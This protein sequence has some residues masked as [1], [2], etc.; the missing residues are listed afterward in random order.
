[1]T[2]FDQIEHAC[3]TDVGVRRSHN[4]D[5]FAVQLAGDDDGWKT[6]GHLFLVAD[7]MGAH[8]VGE[9]ASEQA[10]HIIPHIYQKHAAQGPIAGL[11]KAFVEANASIHQCGQQ[12]REFEGM[13]TTGTAL[14]LRPDGAWVG[15]VGDS[16]C[17]RV[18]GGVIEQLSYDHSLVW[19]YARLQHLDPDEVEDI[20]SNVIHRCLGPEPLVQVDVEGPHDIQPGDVFLLCSDGL[21]GPV[22][23]PEMGAI[24]S[25]LPPAEACRFLIDLANLRGG[26]D[27]IT[28]IVVRVLNTAGAT[29]AKPPKKPL[30]ARLPWWSLTLTAGTV[31]AVMAAGLISQGWTWL[32]TPLLVAAV[33][34]VVAGLIGLGIHYQRE[35]ARGD[36]DEADRPPAKAHRKK[37]C[38]IE[39]P[40]LDRLVKALKTLQQMATDKGWQPDWALFKESQ[41]EAEKLLA[42]GDVSSSFREYCR[43]MLP[44]TRALQEKRHKEEVFRP[45]WDKTR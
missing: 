33:G 7:G 27:N 1:M 29:P 45:V 41:D 19:E 10:S 39:R 28:A 32:A 3:L 35:Q 44:L 21:S 42:A 24:V 23:D 4:Q 15:H 9:K 20:P 25:V 36:D 13:G 38:K 22:S 16:R 31:C 37:A 18:R 30:L 8:A 6:R 11:R 26:P 34:C 12:N 14:L 17:Y 2:R 5:N 43:A 40:L